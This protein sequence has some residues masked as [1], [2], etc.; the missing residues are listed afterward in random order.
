MTASLVPEEARAALEQIVD[1][2]VAG[3]SDLVEQFGEVFGE[4]PESGA[5]WISYGLAQQ[6]DGESAAAIDAGV[7]AR[8]G[9]VVADASDE[10]EDEDDDEQPDDFVVDIEALYAELAVEDSTDDGVED[11]AEDDEDDDE[12]LGLTALFSEIVAGEGDAG[13]PEAPLDADAAEKISEAFTTGSDE[14]LAAVQ[15]EYGVALAAQI[16]DDI[17]LQA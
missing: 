1:G 4:A 16:S 14:D 2:L 8:A 15:E 10:E 12:D 17:P 6:D 5:Q 13:A 3:H 7:D 11:E 9:A